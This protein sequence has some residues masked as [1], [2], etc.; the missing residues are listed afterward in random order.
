MGIA[1]NQDLDLETLWQTTLAQGHRQ[2]LLETIAAIFKSAIEARA[3]K[4]RPPGKAGLRAEKGY[5]RLLYL[6]ADLHQKVK[7]RETTDPQ[8][9]PLNWD[10]MDDMLRQLADLPELRSEIMSEIE[11]ALVAFK[12]SPSMDN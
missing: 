1:L 5:Y 7:T 11:A 9:A 4:M 10:Q 8:A 3:P 12:D 2:P 6:E